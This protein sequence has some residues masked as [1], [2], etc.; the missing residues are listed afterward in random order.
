M[1]KL[2]N[3]ALSRSLDLIPYIFTQKTS[4]ATAS[5]P[6]PSVAEVAP[7]AATED[8]V[9]A[10]TDKRANKK[11]AGSLG[12]S[13]TEPLVHH[14]IKPTI[15]NVDVEEIEQL[16]ATEIAVKEQRKKERK[17][18]KKSQLES[19]EPIELKAAA[20]DVGS[21]R[22]T[23]GVLLQDTDE[24]RSEHED[25]RQP[26]RPTC[27]K[28]PAVTPFT[29]TGSGASPKLARPKSAMDKVKKVAGDDHKLTVKRRS[30]YDRGGVTNEEAIVDVTATN[31]GSGHQAPPLD[32]KQQPPQS[33]TAMASPPTSPHTTKERRHRSGSTK[34]TASAALV[35]KLKSAPSGA[36]VV[37]R[38]PSTA[39]LQDASLASASSRPSPE[40]L[41]LPLANLEV[42]RTTNAEEGD[43]RVQRLTTT[44]RVM[45]LPSPSGDRDN[46]GDDD[47]EEPSLEDSYGVYLMKR[48]KHRKKRKKRKKQ[49]RAIKRASEVEGPPRDGQD[50]DNDG[51]TDEQGDRLFFAH[52]KN[53]FENYRMVDP[54][55]PSSPPLNADAPTAMEVR[56][57]TRACWFIASYNLLTTLPVRSPRILASRCRTKRRRRRRSSASS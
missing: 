20:A 3:D 36:P 57:R 56:L 24:A 2:K 13:S 54:L 16:N 49:E 28:P 47:E 26:P 39:T 51:E 19:A 52:L 5:T 11:R 30:A 35:T 12:R 33:Q 29:P 18:R 41:R 44:K 50:D 34:D 4:A 27:D 9:P 21:P 40:S 14:Q 32:L 25:A 37:R 17:K 22:E 45:A 7:E 8:A 31:E 1:R 38:T 48:M 15:K 53:G 10:P 46:E 23:F 42:L 43:D 55:Q 6:A